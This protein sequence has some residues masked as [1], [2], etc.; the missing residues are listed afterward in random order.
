MEDITE[1]VASFREAARHLWN[2]FFY[3]DADWDDRD[4]FSE[5]CVQLFDALVV[6]H[7]GVAEARLPQMY[8]AHPKA[9]PALRVVPQS[10]LRIH[11]NRSHDVPRGGYWDDPVDMIL[12]PEGVS[13]DFVNFYDFGELARRDFKYLEVEIRE[14]AKHPHLVGRRALVEFDTIRVFVDA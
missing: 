1:S 7:A 3:P 13:F 8:D 9:I 14:L 2:A 5:I 11:I 6:M 10:G 12:S 4:R